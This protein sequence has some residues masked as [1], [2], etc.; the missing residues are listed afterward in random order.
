MSP[1]RPTCKERD[2]Y[3]QRTS[4]KTRRRDRTMSFGAWIR[5]VLARIG[6]LYR[7][8]SN[9]ASPE[10]QYRSLVEHAAYG[11]CRTDRV[12]LFTALNPALAEL[13]GYPD[14]AAVIGLQLNS[15]FANPAEYDRLLETYQR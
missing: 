15:I 2:S 3:I 13:L 1:K 11:I 12:G 4:R 14:A 8:P 10:S 7:P 6:P 9:A 5:S